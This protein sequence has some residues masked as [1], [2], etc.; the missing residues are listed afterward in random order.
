[1]DDRSMTY[2]E[3]RAYMESMLV[4][5]I[6]IGLERITVLL[7]EL[8]HPELGIDTF[9]IAGTNGKGSTSSYVAH[10]LAMAGKKVGWFTSPYLVRFTERMRILEGEA[11]VKAFHDD[12]AAGE[13]S[14]EEFALHMTTVRDAVDKIVAKGHEPPTEF[15]LIMVVAFLFFKSERCDVLVLETGLGGRL[16]ATNVIDRPIATIITSIGHDHHERLGD[17]IEKIAW[18]KSGIIKPNVP[19]F[20]YMPEDMHLTEEDAA[21]VRRVLTDKARAVSAPLRFIGTKDVSILDSSLSGQ[22]FTFDKETFETKHPATYHSIHAALSIAA[23]KSYVSMNALVSGMRAT[24][25]PGRLEVLRTFPFVLLDGAH[26][27][28]G[29]IALREQLDQLLPDEPIV[30]LVG[31]LKDKDIDHMIPPLFKPPVRNLEAV[32]CTTPAS[33]RALPPEE[34]AEKVADAAFAGYNAKVKVVPDPIEAAKEAI[35]IARQRHRKVVAFGSLYLV[36]AIRQTLM[37][38]EP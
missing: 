20:A 16:D 11:G 4:F 18:E 35:S 22:Y 27:P 37:T 30:V 29:V 8:G 17:T 15:E 5:G 34:L 2:E 32:I 13:I 23:T 7:E 25:W 38:F 19:V 28:E 12:D 24:R 26:N 6:R 36:G 21:D 3:A 33:D 31:M 1:M 14:E 10:I 9:H